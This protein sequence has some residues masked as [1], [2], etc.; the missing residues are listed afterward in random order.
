MEPVSTHQTFSQSLPHAQVVQK[1]P[2]VRSDCCKKSPLEQ[3]LHQIQ[4]SPFPQRGGRAG[5]L[6]ENPWSHSGTFDWRGLRHLTPGGWGQ[7][8]RKKK[9][10]PKPKSWGR[11]Q[12]LGHSMGH[13]GMRGMFLFGVAVTWVYKIAKMHCSE[14]VKN[15]TFYGRPQLTKK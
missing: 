14:H 8:S 13:S 7:S 1:R 5:E 11:E 15:C 4:E 2:E 6:R 12:D 10:L 9:D 3:Q